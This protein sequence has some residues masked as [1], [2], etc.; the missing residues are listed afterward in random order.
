MRKLNLGCGHNVLEGW[1]NSDANP[2]S[3]AVTLLDVENKFPFTDNEFDYI[4]SEHMIEHL[5]YEV[6]SRSLKECYR[7]LKPRG[8]VRVSTPDLA[9][10]VDLY[11][12]SEA[13]VNKRYIQWAAKFSNVF[14]S[15]THVINNFVRAW[16]HL[17]IYDEKTLRS[18]LEAAG[19]RNIKRCLINESVHEDLKN[20]ENDS[21]L[22]EGFLALE[23]FTLEGER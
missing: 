18:S 22:P 23:T 13:D 1:V 2:P 10:L 5:P 8:V 7:V 11:T 3:T 20:L 15:N 9:F 12:N 17:F 4:F 19:F 6:G 21:R 14:C 16:G